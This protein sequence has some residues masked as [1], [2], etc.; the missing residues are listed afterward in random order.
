MEKKKQYGLK[1][2]ESSGTSRGY[3]LLK[4]LIYTWDTE[5]GAKGEGPWPN[6]LLAV[7]IGV[8]LVI[9]KFP[10]CNNVLVRLWIADWH[11]FDRF[12]LKWNDSSLKSE[13][14]PRQTS[15][16]GI[17]SSYVT[18]FCSSTIFITC[19]Y[20][21]LHTAPPPPGI[22][23]PVPVPS[24]GWSKIGSDILQTSSDYQMNRNE[25]QNGF[26]F[27]FCVDPKCCLDFTPDSFGEV[28][29]L[30]LQPSTYFSQFLIHS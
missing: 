7:D 30:F 13:I 3:C 17:T 26:G 22:G 11:T 8:W 2:R 29:C 18:V 23:A 19:P 1:I 10:Y 4:G 27:D 16:K 28:S 9:K 24:Q 5:T 14:V 25:E 21:Y 6:W 20:T 15:L 12:I